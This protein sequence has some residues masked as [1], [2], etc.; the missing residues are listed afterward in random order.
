M[1]EIKDSFKQVFHADSHQQDNIY[2]AKV[3]K[4]NHIIKKDV[5]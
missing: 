4:I 5:K 3:D 1:N 2:Q